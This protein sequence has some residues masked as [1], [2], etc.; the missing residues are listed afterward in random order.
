MIRRA[1]RRVPPRPGTLP[2]RASRLPVATG[3][4]DTVFAIFAAHERRRAADREALFAEITRTLR[5]GGTL[6]LVEHLRDRADTA[7]FGPRGLALHAPP[8]VA[9]LADGAGLHTVTETR[10]ATIVTVFAFRRELRDHQRR[11]YSAVGTQRTGR[12]HVVT[13]RPGR[14]LAAGAA[15]RP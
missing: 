8:R 14:R 5:P 7:T 15:V 4:Q 1:C 13:R 12:I 6:I 2:G 3:S 10:I 11:L 9:R